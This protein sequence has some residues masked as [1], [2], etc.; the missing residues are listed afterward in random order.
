MTGGRI[1]LTGILRR[2]L[3][4]HPEVVEALVESWLEDAL[5]ENPRVRL[6]ARGLLLDRVDGPF[7]HEVDP[8][9]TV[10]AAILFEDD[11]LAYSEIPS[12]QRQYPT[13]GWHLP[14]TRSTKSSG[15]GSQL[16]CIPVDL[17]EV[18]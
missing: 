4:E 13:V 6:Q 17:V 1:S 8:Q 3:D 10:E 7:R 15:A 9:V 2:H 14:T 11:S 5:H 18:A 12:R 16:G